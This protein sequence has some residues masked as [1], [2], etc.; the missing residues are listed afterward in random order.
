MG[1]GAVA[2]G[3]EEAERSSGTGGDR[4]GPGTGV[5]SGARIDRRRTGEET[6]I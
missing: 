6:C 5:R 4:D 1:G 2:D 3:R